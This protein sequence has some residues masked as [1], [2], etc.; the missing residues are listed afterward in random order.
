MRC[1]FCEKD[2]AEGEAFT[3]VRQAVFGGWKPHGRGHVMVKEPGEQMVVFHD[4]CGVPAAQPSPRLR[5]VK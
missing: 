5:L 1:I 4:V 2:V 3:A